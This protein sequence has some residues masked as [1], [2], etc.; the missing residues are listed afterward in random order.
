MTGLKL[1]ACTD[2]AG[3]QPVGVRTLQQKP[4]GARS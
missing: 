4:S 3:K 1:F 2:H